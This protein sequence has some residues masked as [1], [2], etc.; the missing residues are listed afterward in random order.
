MATVDSEPLR[1]LIAGTI[2][3]W[4]PKTCLLRVDGHEL[5]VAPDISAAHVA[6]PRGAIRAARCDAVNARLSPMPNEQHI[7]ALARKILQAGGIPR[8]DP[9]GTWGG[10]GVDVPCAI[11]GERIRPEQVE[12]EVQFAHDGVTPGVGAG[13]H[14][15]RS[16]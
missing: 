13:A 15:S 12:Y 5:W 9:D 6:V 3:A 14:E 10:K 16:W 11:C 8:H 4:D 1:F 2:T 7:R